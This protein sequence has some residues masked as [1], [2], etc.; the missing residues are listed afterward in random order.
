M[1]DDKLLSAAIDILE[2]A[3]ALNNHATNL[4]KIYQET[5][6][7]TLD[8]EKLSEVSQKAVDTLLFFKHYE[9]D[10]DIVSQHLR[11]SFWIFICFFSLVAI[12]ML[13]TLAGLNNVG[14]WDYL[15]G[16]PS[17]EKKQKIIMEAFGLEDQSDWITFCANA[18]EFKDLN[19]DQR[20]ILMAYNKGYRIDIYSPHKEYGTVNWEKLKSFCKSPR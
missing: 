10:W 14:V 13:Y 2:S 19:T 4:S 3:K 8:L 6:K 20:L 16:H 9:H 7:T 17:V 15:S 5:A 12:F 11:R 1:R 18:E